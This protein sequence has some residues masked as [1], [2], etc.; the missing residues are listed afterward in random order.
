MIKSE[1]ND[2]KQEQITNMLKGNHYVKRF[3]IMNENSCIE[4]CDDEN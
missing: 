2:Y 1:E 4:S 3:V